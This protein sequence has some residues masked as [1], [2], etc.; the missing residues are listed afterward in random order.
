LV[1]CVRNQNMD[2][3]NLIHRG[4]PLALSEYLKRMPTT[5]SSG[6]ASVK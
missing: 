4:Y 1:E 3:T 5:Q 6:R 2:L